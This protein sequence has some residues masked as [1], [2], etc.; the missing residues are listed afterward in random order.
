[1]F[2]QV[3]IASVGLLPRNEWSRAYSH[4]G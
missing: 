4:S 3:N 2:Q 1:V